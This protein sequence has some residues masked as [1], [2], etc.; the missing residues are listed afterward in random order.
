M[1]LLPGESVIMQSDDKLLTL[2]TQRLRLDAQAGGRSKVVSLTLDSL[3]SCGLVTSSRPF[4][5]G[6]AAL[7]ALGGGVILNGVFNG[8]FTQKATSAAGA[9][10]GLCLACAVVLVLAY[11][12]TRSALLEFES[13]GGEKM[14]VPAKG[15]AR[16]ALVNFLDAVELAKLNHLSRVTE[17]LIHPPPLAASAGSPTVVVAGQ[18]GSSV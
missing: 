8:R 16:E 15:L 11:L 14:P 5:L 6:L 17:G 10:G 2:T 4:L 18:R 9:I 7:S 1:K 12:L 13:M 3:S